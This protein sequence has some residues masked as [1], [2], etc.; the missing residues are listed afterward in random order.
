MVIQTYQEDGYCLKTGFSEGA[1]D[2]IVNNKAPYKVVGDLIF[3]ERPADILTNGKVSHIACLLNYFPNGTAS[4]L[5]I[6]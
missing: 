3:L 4:G 5:V 6:A 2:F 1:N